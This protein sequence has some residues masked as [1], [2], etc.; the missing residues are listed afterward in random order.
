M[1]QQVIYE[2]RFIRVNYDAIMSGQLNAFEIAVYVVLCGYASNQDNSCFP[3]YRILAER[4]GCS[5]RTAI[6][7]ISRLEELGYIEKR[8]QPGPAGFKS[9]LYIIKDTIP[10]ND[11]PVENRVEK[12][13]AEQ[14]SVSDSHLHSDTDS[15][16]MVSESHRPGARPS[17]KLDVFNYKYF[18]YPQS[19]IRAGADEDGAMDLLK[20]EIDY[21]FFESQYPDRLPFLDSLLAVILSLRR[22]DRP[23]NRRLLAGVNSCTITE[24]MDDLKDKNLNDVRNLSAWLRTVFMEFMRKQDAQLKDFW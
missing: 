13:P 12:L 24:F 16:P 2:S 23:E 6:R 21:D 3:S 20:T 11:N 1:S 14:E 5:R 4:A 18:N 17:P 22:E 19:S 15:P 10:K 8:N 7:T 9:N